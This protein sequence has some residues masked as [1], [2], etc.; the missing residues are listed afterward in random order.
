MADKNTPG[1]QSAIYKKINSQLKVTQG[2]LRDQAVLHQSINSVLKDGLE[3]ASNA[4]ERVDAML[5]KQGVDLSNSFSKTARDHGSM[6]EEIGRQSE[7]MEGQA[8]QSKLG[9]FAAVKAAKDEWAAGL[10]AGK[11]MTDEKMLAAKATLDKYGGDLMSAY[12]QIQDAVGGNVLGATETHTNDMTKFLMENVTE[13]KHMYD[14]QTDLTDRAYTTTFGTFE[15]FISHLESFGDRGLVSYQMLNKGAA[16]SLLNNRMLA[17]GMGLTTAE[18]A[19]LQE[20]H[21]SRTGE[22]NS[23]MMLEMAT[24]AKVLEKTT[25]KSSKDMAKAMSALIRDSDKFANLSVKNA[26]KAA[27]AIGKIGMSVE[28]LSSMMSGFD[29]FDRSI[30]SAATLQSVFGGVLDPIEMMFAA[31][32]DP[33]GALMQ[34]QQWFRS[35]GLDISQM[36]A[37]GKDLIK[38]VLPGLDI[39]TI[40]RMFAEGAGP[41]EIAEITKALEGVETLSPKD[42]MQELEGDLSL[43]RDG[44]IT[45]SDVF[46]RA[47]KGAI[48]RLTPVMAKLGLQ[49]EKTARQLPITAIEQASGAIKDVLSLSDKDIADMTKNLNALGD[50]FVT[51]FDKAGKL[52]FEG[53]MDP[54]ISAMDK[55]AKAAVGGIIKYF[56]EAGPELEKLFTQWGKWIAQAI[57]P[58]SEPNSPLPPV[59]AAILRYM[60]KTAEDSVAGFNNAFEPKN[61]T[62]LK[63]FQGSM[64]EAVAGQEIK[65]ALKEFVNMTD[66]E[67]KNL[68]AKVRSGDFDIGSLGMPFKRFD[69]STDEGFQGLSEK[70]NKQLQD[71]MLKLT[72]QINEGPLTSVDAVYDK[73]TEMGSPLA[74]MVGALKEAKVP[75]DKLTGSTKTML[76]DLSNIKDEEL[77]KLAYEGGDEMKK[78]KKDY[79]HIEDK[80]NIL[81]QSSRGLGSLS[82]RQQ[83]D[84]ANSLKK[85]GLDAEGVAEAMEDKS[86]AS[87][88]KILDSQKERMARVVSLRADSPDGLL[89]KERMVKAEQ[90]SNRLSRRGDS[91]NTGNL[92]RSINRLTKALSTKGGSQPVQVTAY[93]KL[94]NEQL[95]LLTEK[96]VNTPT[97]TG[98]TVKMAPGAED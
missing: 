86:G 74:N 93:L 75:F 52:D 28:Q 59:Q 87:V 57:A 62:S 94:G 3:S 84:M 48:T 15:N 71:S 67:L 9:I 49:G 32:N 69:I 8:K 68:E 6:T 98:Q 24:Y 19:E 1:M 7:Q 18:M 26:A 73:F 89:P 22:V 44:A 83:R 5:R 76:K 88:Q 35:T 47:L 10:A 56:K 41:E 13:L 64:K 65:G 31:K 25:G 17:Q 12:T 78:F 46:D 39:P 21:L 36:G 14:S 11:D 66:D 38:D 50:G 79:G 40:E 43:V 95:Q 58:L 51:F 53:S 91:V 77:L 96:I 27:G 20:R 61:F 70:A 90:E 37:Y 60:N 80:L 23:D 29:G 34:L 97:P 63:D 72:A 92:D 45:T 54:L 55:I 30:E 2:L 33:G 42:A 4:G 81:K 82:I 16:E 85:M